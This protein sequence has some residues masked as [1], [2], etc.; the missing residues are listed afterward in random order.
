MSVPLARLER[1]PF[2]RPHLRLL[3]MGGLG[4]TFDGLDVAVLAFVLPVIAKQ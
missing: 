4:L 2:C 3:A 1:I